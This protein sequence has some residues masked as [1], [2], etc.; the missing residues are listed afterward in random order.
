M[1]TCLPGRHYLPLDDEKKGKYYRWRSIWNPEGIFVSFLR[2]RSV[3][4]K[5]GK[6]RRF[7]GR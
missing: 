5:G 1:N 2:E 4:L 7:E 3:L 6:T